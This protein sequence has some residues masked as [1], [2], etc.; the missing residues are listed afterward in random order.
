MPVNSALT[1]SMSFQAASLHHEHVELPLAV[2]R[3]VNEFQSVS[4]AKERY[5][6]VLRYAKQLPALD[7]SCKVA[8][9]RVMGCT[10]EVYMTASLDSQNCVQFAGDSNSELTRGL[11]A[12]LVQS[13]SGLTPAEVLKV[14][15]FLNVKLLECFRLPAALYFDFMPSP[16][17]SIKDFASSC[18]APWLHVQASMSSPAKTYSFK[19]WGHSPLQL[20]CCV[21]LM[22]IGLAATSAS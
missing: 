2:Q 8:P 20:V 3:I 4:D 6:L 17:Y 14:C 21:C 7:E 9:N 11:C 15:G 10:S 13:M 16:A 22:Y 12:I 5:K 1:A 18:T 19:S